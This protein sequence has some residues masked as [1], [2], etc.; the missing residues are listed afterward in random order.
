[1]YPCNKD[2]VVLYISLRHI[3]F[4]DCVEESRSRTM[5]AVP[6]LLGQLFLYCNMVLFVIMNFHK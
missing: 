3:V 6:T 2:G 5:Q 4:A 1:M